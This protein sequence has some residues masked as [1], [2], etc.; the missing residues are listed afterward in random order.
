LLFALSED[1]CVSIAA[2]GTGAPDR[3]VAS[4]YEETEEGAAL[5]TEVEAM[6]FWVSWEVGGRGDCSSATAAARFV[7]HSE[8]LTWRGE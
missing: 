5:A 8:L 1:E 3:A 2:L 7:G 6:S 4:E